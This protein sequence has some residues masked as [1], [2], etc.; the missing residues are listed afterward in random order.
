MIG[1]TFVFRHCRITPYRG[2]ETVLSDLNGFSCSKS[3]IMIFYN[4]FETDKQ[5]KNHTELVIYA[6][7]LTKP[8]SIFNEYFP[9]VVVVWSFL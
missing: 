7:K 1:L 3:V 4:S 9:S 2:I 6:F 8:F 5:C